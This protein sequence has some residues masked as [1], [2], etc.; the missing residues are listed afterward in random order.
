MFR[1]WVVD[2]FH[3]GVGGQVPIRGGL[4]VSLTLNSKVTHWVNRGRL[5][6]PAFAGF[7][8]SFVWI[9]QFHRRFWFRC[10]QFSSPTFSRCPPLP[11]VLLFFT[12]MWSLISVATLI[13][14][15]E[16]YHTFWCSHRPLALQFLPLLGFI[17]VGVFFPSL[18]LVLLFVSAGGC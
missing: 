3:V 1:Y 18:L 10:M 5:H 14:L 13:Y 2:S 8:Q 7:Y 16:S 4:V 12:K 6:P 11:L 17:V 9:Y 15:L